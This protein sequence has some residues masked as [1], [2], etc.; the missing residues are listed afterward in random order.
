MMRKLLALTIVAL[1]VAFGA[2]GVQAVGAT[3]TTYNVTPDGVAI[4]G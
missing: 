2:A 4:S 3:C 1:G